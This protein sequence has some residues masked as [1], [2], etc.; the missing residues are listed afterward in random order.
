M[1]LLC[2]VVPQATA[3]ALLLLAL[4]PGAAVRAAEGAE[5][6]AAG[7]EKTAN[8]HGSFVEECSLCHSADAWTPARVSTKFKH[9]KF[10]FPLEGAHAQA[11]CSSCHNSLEFAK[12]KV[13]SNCVSCHQDVHQGELG[14]DCARCHSTRSF[15]D[16]SRMARAHQSTRFPL[17]GA[18]LTVDCRDCHIGAPQGHLTYVNLRTDCEAC[19]LDDYQATTNPNHVAGNYPKDC[20]NCHSPVAWRPGR[21]VNHDALYFPIYSGVHR[22]RWSSCSDCHINPAN[23][24]QFEC[25]LCHKHDDP[26][27]TANKHVGVSGYQYNSQACYTCHPQ[28]RK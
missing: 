25:I 16:H 8:P 13:K 28:G 23:N 18:H 22:G 14:A 5:P 15:I 20:L 24:T 1:S 10:G 17:T 21:S 6:K 12:V 7:Q 26:V 9:A 27:E 2:R 3:F 11:S 4:A 19:H